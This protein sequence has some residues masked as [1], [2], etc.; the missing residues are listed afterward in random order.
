MISP[1][2]VEKMRTWRH[3]GLHA[4]AG[5]E[6]PDI[7]DAVRVGFQMVR[8]SATASRLRADP[9]QEPRLRYR[10]PGL[11][12]ASTR[13]TRLCRCGQSMRV[14]EFVARAPVI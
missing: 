2:P 9:H 7:D 1:E 10:G 8:G 6:I 5:D 4:F 12:A 11:S 3:S 13:P 14:V